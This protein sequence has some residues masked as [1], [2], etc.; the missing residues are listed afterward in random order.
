MANGGSCNRRT[1]TGR[2]PHHREVP[3]LLYR[4]SL[5]VWYRLLDGR[6]WVGPFASAGGS[7]TLA[8]REDFTEEQ[9]RRWRTRP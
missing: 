4:A 7:A 8:L 2:C 3:R 1:R 5:L 6:F 9:R